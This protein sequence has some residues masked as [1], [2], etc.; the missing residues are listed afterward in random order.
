[1]SE[2]ADNITKQ[3]LIDKGVLVQ[4]KCTTWQYM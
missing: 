1:M 2:S 4:L 3:A